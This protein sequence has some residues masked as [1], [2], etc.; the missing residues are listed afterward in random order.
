MFALRQKTL[1]LLCGLITLGID[2][3]LYKLLVLL[4]MSTSLAKG[5]SFVLAL[6]VSY[7][8]N[9]IFV[10][11]C[12]EP[13]TRFHCYF[14]LAIANI[15]VNILINE[16]SLILIGSDRINVCFVI[17]TGVT[18][19]CSYWGQQNWVFKKQSSL[20]ESA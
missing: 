7:N 4:S 3:S 15:I 1:Y 9:R 13:G 12:R 18:V 17:A 14:I 10:F 8:L 5:M 6:A 16:I 20:G 11:R 2:F 19:A